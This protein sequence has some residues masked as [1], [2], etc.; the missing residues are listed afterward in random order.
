MF[1]STTKKSVAPGESS[2]EL[3]TKKIEKRRVN[4][5]EVTGSGRATFVQECRKIASK[6]GRHNKHRMHMD[7]L[8][9]YR[10]DI[11]AKAVQYDSERPYIRFIYHEILGYAREH[12]TKL[13]VV[14]KAIREM[15]EVEGDWFYYADFVSLNTVRFQTT[16]DFVSVLRDNVQPP[17]IISCFDERLMNMTL[18]HI[19]CPPN[20]RSI[21][22]REY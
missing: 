6:R 12:D 18:I 19:S 1:F 20:K 14:D 15:M 16:T 3:L 17:S 7:D 2:I 8:L 22:H 13:R 9:Q 10:K 11:L 4:R 21:N 5:I